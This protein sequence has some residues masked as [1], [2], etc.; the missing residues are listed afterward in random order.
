MTIDKKSA[1]NDERIES[2][3]KMFDLNNDGSIS[4]KEFQNMLQGQQKV[5]NEVW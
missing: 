2:C 5:T 3:F 4:L 1:L